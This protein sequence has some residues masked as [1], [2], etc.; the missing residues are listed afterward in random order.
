MI[1]ASFLVKDLHLEWQHGARHFLHWLVDGDLASNQHGWQWAAGCGTDAAPYFR[2]FNPTSQGRK[3][4]PRRRT[5]GGGCPSWPTSPTR[6]TR[7][8]TTATGS[9]TR[10]RSS[11]TPP[12]AARRWPL[13]GDPLTCVAPSRP[14]ARPERPARQR[15]PVPDLLVPRRFCGPRRRATAAGPPAR[16]R[17]S[18]TRPRS[19]VSL[20]RR[21]RWTPRCPSTSSTADR[22]DVDGAPVARAEAADVER[23]VGRP[24]AGR[25]G[26]SRGGVVRRARARTRSRPASSCGTDRDRRAADLPGTGRRPG[27]PARVAATW[28]PGRVACADDL[29][30]VTWA[31]L[32]CV[33][34]WA[35]DLEE[36]RWCWPG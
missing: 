22:R 6:T 4:D 34:G 36:R 2:V 28:T 23:R 32:D 25:G 13:G 26:A 9:A 3:F 14:A 27:R 8:P 19:S 10:C 31:A 24:G 11:T 35:G 17:P 33:G 12:S 21:R 7:R 1:V 15:R 20:L 18:S 29:A 5:S 16:S 30:A